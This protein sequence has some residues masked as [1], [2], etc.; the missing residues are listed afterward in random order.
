[1][2]HWLPVLD[3]AYYINV[4]DI[5]ALQPSATIVGHVGC[6][7]LFHSRKVRT[8]DQPSLSQY[9]RQV[10]AVAAKLI[11]MQH[12]RLIHPRSLLTV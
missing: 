3:L 6:T 4:S 8:S 12:I 2:P 10:Q 1:M 5:W 7:T 9:I 11:E